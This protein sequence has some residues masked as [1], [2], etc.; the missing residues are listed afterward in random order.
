M[1][2]TRFEDID[3]YP[4]YPSEDIIKM[5]VDYVIQNSI[6]EDPKKTLSKLGDLGDKQWHTYQELPIEYKNNIKEFLIRIW[7]N[8]DNEFLESILSI[9]YCFALEKGFYKKAFENYS[10]NFKSDFERDLNASVGEFINP[11]W[12]LKN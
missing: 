8:N 9:S 10:G 2:I 3:K 7:N 12:T 11:W 5:F 1:V 4:E 6:D